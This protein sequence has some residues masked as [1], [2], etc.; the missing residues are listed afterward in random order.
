MAGSAQLVRRCSGEWPD[1]AD[2]AADDVEDDVAVVAI[3]RH[4]DTGVLGSRL[5]GIRGEPEGLRRKVSLPIGESVRRVERDGGEGECL[6][7][8][9]SWTK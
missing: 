9:S 4:G 5:R 2:L 6:L 8:E 7:C 1:A 3:G